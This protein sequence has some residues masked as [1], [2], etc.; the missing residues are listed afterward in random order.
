VPLGGAPSL[1]ADA[2]GD[3]VVG[4]A[5]AGKATAAVYTGAAT[6]RPPQPIKPIAAGDQTAAV[7]LTYYESRS[8]FIDPDNDPL[9]YTATLADSRPLPDWLHIDCDGRLWGTPDASAAGQTYHVK[10]TASDPYGG[11]ASLV[12]P[13]TVG[14]DPSMAAG[15]QFTVTAGNTDVSYL[16]QP[17]TAVNA[18]GEAMVIWM[19]AS[20]HTSVMMG[21]IY[22]SHHHPTGAP[23]PISP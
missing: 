10:V 21:K 15:G 5:P 19:A 3:F 9:A 22:D 16:T 11:S 4:W 7:R 12:L 18:V 14:P 8:Y 20:D 2:G 13:L 23:F 1:A 17:T 6:N